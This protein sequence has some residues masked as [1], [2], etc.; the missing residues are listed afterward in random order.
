LK[1]TL[2]PYTAVMEWV[3]TDKAD[4]LKMA[5]LVTVFT[6]PVPSVV[7]PSLKVTVPP[8]A[9]LNAGVM[10]AVNVTAWPFFDGFSED[11]SFVV[12]FAFFTVCVNFAEVLVRKSTFPE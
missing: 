11:V 2:P 7:A 1:F 3:A 6:A 10:V 5:C 8:G 4:V 12:V 9:P